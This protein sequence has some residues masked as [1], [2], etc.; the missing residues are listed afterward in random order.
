MLTITTYDVMQLQSLRSGEPRAPRNCSQEAV[1][2]AIAG[3]TKEAL[4]YNMF[5]LR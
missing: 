4:H 1:P 5:Q 2:I 3:R